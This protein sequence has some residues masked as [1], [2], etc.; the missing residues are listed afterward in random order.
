MVVFLF[1][2]SSGIVCVVGINCEDG[3]LKISDLDLFFVDKLCV[4]WVIKL[5]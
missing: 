2:G 5:L 4:R 3:V 1:G